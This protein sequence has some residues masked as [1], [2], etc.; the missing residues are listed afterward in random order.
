VMQLVIKPGS[1]PA[2]PCFVGA[3]GN[4]WKASLSMNRSP[5]GCSRARPRPSSSN[6]S[7]R[8]KIEH[9]DEGRGTRDEDE[10][11]WQVHRSDARPILEAETRLKSCYF[12][13]QSCNKAHRGEGWAERPTSAFDPLRFGRRMTQENAIASLDRRDFLKTALA[14]TAL[15]A[16]DIEASAAVK[17]SV[18][19][20][21]LI[22]VNVNVSRW[23]LR[24]VPADDT[25]ALVAL[26]R[27]QGVRQAWAGSFDG[28]LHKDIAAVNARLADECRRHGRGLLLPFGSINPGL[29]N[30]EEDL[31]RCAEEH[32]MPGIRL[33]P[34]YHGYK[35]DDP[36]LARL[37]RLATERRL[38]V[39]LALVMEDER[40]MHPLLR[41][42]PADTTPLAGLVK[43]TPG[44]R[45]VLLNALRTLRSQPL[46]DLIAAGEV[47][48]EISMLEGVGGVANLLGQVPASRVLFGSHAPLFYFESALLKLKESPLS[49]EQLRAICSG[50]ARALATNSAQ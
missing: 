16:L 50:N 5:A 12:E 23:P 36:H 37:L 33:H 44:L 25:T 45:L 30:W 48:V 3:S 26:L 41:V 21:G 1:L 9:E 38:I 24:R 4:R 47:Y 8:Q 20:A 39:Q 34:N 46:L 35:L 18:Y 42:E 17:P 15:V 10:L 28:L 2:S 19:P 22:D 31:R 6:P 14:A 49:E 7:L 32:H 11:A 27:R 40:M 13:S 43:H 29:P